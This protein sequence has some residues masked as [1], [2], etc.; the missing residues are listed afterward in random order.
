MRFDWR[1]V[2]NGRNALIGLGLVGAVAAVNL[3][4]DAIIKVSEEDAVCVFDPDHPQIAQLI[5]M[6]TGK[7]FMTMGRDAVS[8]P[9]GSYVY[10]TGVNP[11]TNIPVTGQGSF[12]FYS[13]GMHGEG[14]PNCFVHDGAGEGR[15]FQAMTY[16]QYYKKV[17]GLTNG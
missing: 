7:A 16:D 9:D 5:N 11:F 6:K 13:A 12:N 1:T 17:A 8:K 4:P 14:K 10:G 3:M 2:V 15:L